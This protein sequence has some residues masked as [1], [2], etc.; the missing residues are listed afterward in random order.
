MTDQKV[1]EIAIKFN[2][3]CREAEERYDEPKHVFAALLTL[4]DVLEGNGCRA[5]EERKE[6]VKAVAGLAK[7]VSLSSPIAVL[8]VEPQ[9][10]VEARVLKDLENLG[11]ESLEDVKG[12]RSVVDKD[13]F[14]K[15]RYCVMVKSRLARLPDH[16]NRAAIS[17]L[18]S[19]MKRENLTL[20]FLD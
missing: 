1:D 14:V 3:Y 15:K 16:W 13:C 12:L 11:C 4:L 10:E 9:T 8:G 2:K 19:M 7:D 17:A 6:F 18:Y 5:N 20:I